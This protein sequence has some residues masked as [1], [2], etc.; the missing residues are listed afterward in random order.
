MENEKS[1]R[2][3]LVEVY[4]RSMEEG[5]RDSA[6]RNLQAIYRYYLPGSEDRTVQ[7]SRCHSG[8]YSR[9][10]CTSSGTQRYKCKGCGKVYCFSRTRAV[11]AH[12]KLPVEKWMG[13]AECFVDDLSPRET[14]RKIGVT[15]E[16]AWFM[17]DRTKTLLSLSISIPMKCWGW[18]IPRDDMV[19]RAIVFSVNCIAWTLLSKN[20]TNTFLSPWGLPSYSRSS[21]PEDLHQGL[22]SGSI[23]VLKVPL[24]ALPTKRSPTPSAP[25]GRIPSTV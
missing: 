24:W 25:I 19:I 11:I 15:Q 1:R 21:P 17:G 23:W 22:F 20:S 6:I 18:C 7:C 16:T 12:T 14:Q 9:Y 8:E 5:D 3:E 4:R 10:G 13:F 2:K